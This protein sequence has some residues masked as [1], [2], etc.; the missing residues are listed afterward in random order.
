MRYS[1]ELQLNAEQRAAL[2][3]LRWITNFTCKT[4]ERY[5][6]HALEGIYPLLGPGFE[7]VQTTHREGSDI[8]QLTHRSGVPVTLAAVYDG[9]GSI[10]TV[11]LYGTKGQTPLLCRDYYTAFR[12]QLLSFI[13]ML[14]SGRA[15][16]DFSQTLEMM[17][18][19][20]AG[21]RSREQAGTK[22][23]VKDILNETNAP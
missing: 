19:I 10:G 15:P 22:I 23:Y 1:P 17:A 21:R 2:G 13:T 5:G 4:W 7:T 8:V 11:H 3:E 14:R 16:F 20:I 18:I 9:V 12:E 6:I